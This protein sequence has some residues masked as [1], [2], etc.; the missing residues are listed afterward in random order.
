MKFN[1]VDLIIIAFIALG[2]IEGISRGLILSLF[3]FVGIFFSAYLA[4]IISPIVTKTVINNTALYK[5]IVTII[6]NKIEKNGNKTLELLNIIKIKQIPTVEGIA[7]MIINIIVYIALIVI[8][9]TMSGLILR[10]VMKI[11]RKTPLGLLDTIGGIGFG[12]FKNLLIIFMLF[13]FLTPLL[14]IFPHGNKIAEAI[15]T[16][17]LGNYFVNYNFVIPWI[18]KIPELKL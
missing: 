18:Q 12:V 15:S 4:K 17:Y 10:A 16:S 3:H 5:T 14:A 2:I 7:I 1:I 11:I 9:L 6:N 13:A 8:L